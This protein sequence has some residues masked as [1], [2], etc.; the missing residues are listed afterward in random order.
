MTVT[1]QHVCE[2]SELPTDKELVQWARQA[3]AE[4]E[5][6][7]RIVDE[8]ESA[9]LNSQYRD[10]PGPT[11]VLSFPADHESLP[12]ELRCELG[13]LVVCAPVVAREALEQGKAMDA[14]WAHMVVHG[15]LHLRGFDHVE[16]ADAERMEALEIEILRDLGYSNPYE[17]A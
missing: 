6:T 16:A 14:H 15:V 7:I 1:I 9:V 13:D 3:G 12:E 17:D 4:R 11:N 10:K 2:T 8:A 5:L